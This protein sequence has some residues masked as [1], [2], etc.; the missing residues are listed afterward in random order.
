MPVTAGRAADVEVVA[1]GGRCDGVAA[2][3][4]SVVP[5]D[6]AVD[7]AGNVYV[8]EGWLRRV[9]ATTGIISTIADVPVYATDI[10]TD[11][12]GRVVIGAYYGTSGVFRYDPRAGTVERLT[13]DPDNCRLAAEI[14]ASEA[15][16]SDPRNIAI[17]P[18]GAIY[19]SQ[20][21]GVWRI[22]AATGLITVETVASDVEGYV[23]GI[24]VDA[25]GRLYVAYYDR[26]LRVERETG[27]TIRLA[28]GDLKRECQGSDGDGGPATAACIAA[29]DIA[30]EADG[31]VIF[32]D[33]DTRRYASSMRRPVR[34]AAWVV[35]RVTPSPLIG[36]DSSTR[37]RAST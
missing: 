13:G 31:D 17:G 20:F 14:P 8:S 23:Q 32:P 21:S 28:G 9:D 19:G 37:Q 10:A 30:V 25:R 22:D 7:E 2:T 15:C 33:S 3:D 24:A 4:A 34:S 36:R 11:P 29:R 6:V 18:D 16:V 27:A 12:E 26:L 35:P 1:G 5:T